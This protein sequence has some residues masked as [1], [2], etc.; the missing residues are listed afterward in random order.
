MFCKL[1]KIIAGVNTYVQQ[2]SLNIT[3]LKE[4]YENANFGQLQL[5]FFP[6]ILFYLENQ[7]NF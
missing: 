4:I 3:D 5:K 2:K 1:K 6:Y 7:K